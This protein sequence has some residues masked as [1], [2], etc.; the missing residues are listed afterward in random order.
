MACLLFVP[1]ITE[2][3]QVVFER[4]EL[5]LLL[6]LTRPCNKNSLPPSLGLP[7]NFKPMWCIKFLAPIVLGATLVGLEGVFQREKRNTFEI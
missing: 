6:D 5:K 3:P 4:T 7:L 2:P 1:G